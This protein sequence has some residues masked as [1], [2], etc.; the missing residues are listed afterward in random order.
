MSLLDRSIH[1]KEDALG[2]FKL[3]QSTGPGSYNITIP[4]SPSMQ[5]QYDNNDDYANRNKVIDLL[6]DSNKNTITSFNLKRRRQRTFFDGS[7][8]LSNIKAKEEIMNQSL[9]ENKETKLKFPECGNKVIFSSPTKTVGNFYYPYHGFDKRK[10]TYLRGVSG[11]PSG[12]EAD[13]CKFDGQNHTNNKIGKHGFGTQAKRFD[14]KKL[15]DER[16][17]NTCVGPGK[18]FVQNESIGDKQAKKKYRFDKLNAENKYLLH[19]YPFETNINHFVGFSN[20]AH[21]TMM[22]TNE[23]MDSTL[24]VDK[25]LRRTQKGQFTNSSGMTS[26]YN[27]VKEVNNG[28]VAASQKSRSGSNK[29]KREYKSGLVNRV[30]D[31]VKYNEHGDQKESNQHQNGLD[32]NDFTVIFFWLM[33][34]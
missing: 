25:K 32:P 10:Q 15:D 28:N 18:Y 26:T 1:T 30:K 3:N 17:N 31:R 9:Q 33:N 11:G 23:N 24:Y 20:N 6:F 5:K 22:N 16:L 27:S 34:R 29:S 2:E 13:Y 8:V 12:G 14:T 4:I 7:G 19:K 21:K